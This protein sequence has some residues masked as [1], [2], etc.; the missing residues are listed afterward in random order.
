M[1]GEIV[2]C[3]SKDAV[4]WAEERAK[5]P[6]MDSQLTRYTKGGGGGLTPADLRD[7]AL[8][9]TSITQGFEPPAGAAFLA[10]FGG[11][12]GLSRAAGPARHMADQILVRDKLA[13]GTLRQGPLIGLCIGVIESARRTYWLNKPMPR[14]EMARLAGIDRNQFR[15]NGWPEV[16]GEARHLLWA[17]LKRTER[18]LDDELSMRGWL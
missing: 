3:S 14:D 12:R 1:A 9:I 17:M 7:I 10:V 11:D 5:R 15:R 4:A 16:T 8:T 2:F 13:G 6:D 18:Y